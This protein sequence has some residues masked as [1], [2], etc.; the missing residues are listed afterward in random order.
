MKSMHRTLDALENRLRLLQLE[1]AVDQ[2]TQDAWSP[3][4]RRAAAEARR[5]KS[6]RIGLAPQA[7]IIKNQEIEKKRV[8][9]PHERANYKEL[10]KQLK[11]RG[12]HM[13]AGKKIGKTRG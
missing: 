9:T 4:A 3:E 12:L 7:E 5:R 11:E 6:G 13:L 8:L 10:R 2:L 1:R